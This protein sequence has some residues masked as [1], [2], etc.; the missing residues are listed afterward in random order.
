MDKTELVDIIKG[1]IAMEQTVAS[2]YRIFMKLF[3][4]EESFWE[5]L[6]NDEMQHH[7]WLTDARYIEAVDLL[8]SGDMLPS[9]RHIE[10]SLKSAVTTIEQIKSRPVTFE[11]ALRIALRFEK[12]MVEIFANEL[13]ANVFASGYESLS[14]RIA[15]AERLHLN[16]IEDMMIEKGFMQLS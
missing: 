1:C 3:P 12:S 16:K 13:M 6:F 10:S 11:E 5:D 8:P 15:A 9:A 7:S 4:E 2:I 14:Q